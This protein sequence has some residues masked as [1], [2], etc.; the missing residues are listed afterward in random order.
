MM[1]DGWQYGSEQVDRLREG[2]VAC[3]AKELLE[4]GE[5][6]ETNEVVCGSE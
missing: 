3:Y 4:P 1:R 6:G 2:A 5:R